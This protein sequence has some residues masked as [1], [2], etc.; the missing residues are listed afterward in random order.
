MSSHSKTSQPLGMGFDKARGNKPAHP[1]APRWILAII[2]LV[3]VLI[4][5][6]GASMVEA[7]ERN[8]VSFQAY[9]LERSTAV[10]KL[11]WYFQMA[12]MG[13]GLLT[14]IGYV[15]IPVRWWWWRKTIRG[16]SGEYMAV[17]LPRPDGK[18]TSTSNNPDAP[19]VFWDRLFKIIGRAKNKSSNAY[20]AAELWGSGSGRVQWAFYLP[21]T[22]QTEREA[23]RR[24]I[25]AERPQ[26]RLVTMPDPLEKALSLDPSDPND[27]GERYYAGAVLNL[28]T[29]DFYPLPV[30]GLMLPS[31]V[32]T[33]R[34][35]TGVL[36]SGVSVVVSPASYLWARRV[37][38]L[39]QRWLYHSHDYKWDQRFGEETKD[40]RMKVQQNHARTCVRVQVIATTKDGAVAERDALITSLESSERQYSLTSQSLKV[41]KKIVLQ[42]RKPAPTKKPGAIEV[43]AHMPAGGRPSA[44][45]VV[46]RE[47][48]AEFRVR[49]PFRPDIRNLFIIPF[50]P[51]S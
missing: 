43:P 18:T 16:F 19:F 45:D 48:P 46:V 28:R 7:V 17:V 25:T 8:S 42:L 29:R 30:D 2:S 6:F 15:L 27:T 31:L 5:I 26:A 39:V 20:L 38:Q 32:S 13:I 35:R 21:S 50:P 40:I 12:A 44:T 14:A 3:V 41:R 47:I 1:D 22:L 34:P 9:M 11:V 51:F 4:G 36:R 10:N 23:I 49:A 24:L 37:N 33:L